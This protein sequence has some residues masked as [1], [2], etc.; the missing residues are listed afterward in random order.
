MK[1]STM[2][3][4]RITSAAVAAIAVS[5]MTITPALGQSTAQEVDD[6]RKELETIKRR[7][8][9]LEGGKPGDARVSPSRKK[10][11]LEI[12]GHVNRAYLYADNGT[13]GDSFFVDNDNSGTRFWFRGETDAGDWT[14]GS[15]LA[16][17]FE[18]N[19]TD[20]IS[21]GDTDP[22]VEDS[23]V[24]LLTLR[25]AEVYFKHKRI[26]AFYLGHGSEAANGAM[27]VDLSGTTL[28][29]ESDV[30]DTAG[31]LEF[32][33]GTE[34]D[35]YFRNLDGSRTSRV[36]YRT[37][38]VG[39]FK[40]AVALRQENGIQPDFGLTYSGELSGWELEA[41]VGF[42]PEDDPGTVDDSN[43]ITSS[44]SVLAPFGV[45]L[46][47]GASSQDFD[48]D[49]A[50]ADQSATYVKLGY[51]KKFFDAGETRFSID[52]FAGDSDQD[53]LAGDATETESIGGG[54][55]QVVK[56]LSTELFIGARVYSIDL[57]G[58]GVDPDDLTAF[59]TG[60]RVRF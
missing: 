27:E 43:V 19:S 45:N 14:A 46:T 60:A 55:V 47:V 25:E 32:D 34:L 54:I 31:G 30:D 42:R 26:G 2:I 11:R 7:I 4:R 17:N 12:G 59:I 38:R 13:E 37:P 5:A 39:G 21:F 53:S 15:S 50:H 23:S 44:V 22:V 3:R 49:V 10:V 41:A 16:I 33:N 9:G 48:D 57:P 36:A 20:D 52:Y 28:I 24:D 6:L 56:S 58:A 1:Q 18:S 40:A 29:A 51:R 35:R 8:E